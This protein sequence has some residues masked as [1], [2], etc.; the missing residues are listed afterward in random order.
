LCKNRQSPI[1]DEEANDMKQPTQGRGPSERSSIERSP[2]AEA[3]SATT[4]TAGSSGVTGK[5][6]KVY[7]RPS[8][9]KQRSVYQATLIS[10]GGTSGTLT[11]GAP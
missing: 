10:S 7:Q 2:A 8:V 4:A 3:V 1:L 5:P 11:S 6:R 9:M